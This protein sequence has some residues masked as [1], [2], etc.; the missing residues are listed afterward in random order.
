MLFIFFNSSLNFAAIY[1]VYLLYNNLNIAAICIPSPK[2]GNQ[3]AEGL[4]W[5]RSSLI[6]SVYST[7]RVVKGL[8][9]PCA[10]PSALLLQTKKGDNRRDVI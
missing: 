6:V 10:D 7:H 1:A 3:G 2:G 8:A 9:S 5:I 4:Q